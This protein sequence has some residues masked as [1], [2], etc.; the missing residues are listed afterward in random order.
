MLYIRW[1]PYNSADPLMGGIKFQGWFL[2]LYP[3]RPTVMETS[4]PSAQII[5]WM[6]L[7]VLTMGFA[8]TLVNFLP[9]VL[10]AHRQNPSWKEFVD[11]GGPSQLS[12]LTIS[13][14]TMS[15]RKFDIIRNLIGAIG[16][17]PINSYSDS[18]AKATAMVHL[19]VDEGHR[20][21]V[22]ELYAH[23]AR[24]LDIPVVSAKMSS[25]ARDREAERRAKGKDSSTLGFDTLY[26]IRMWA[27]HLADPYRVSWEQQ[28]RVR[29][30]FR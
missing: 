6:L 19:L 29:C 5:L 28:S 22:K 16:A 15:E 25:V 8:D 21:W 20:E 9:A 12:S 26:F 11:G 7:A 18:A 10:T 30:V 3:S 14:I 13:S 1:G 24:L 27:R 17:Y 4:P 2:D 23:F